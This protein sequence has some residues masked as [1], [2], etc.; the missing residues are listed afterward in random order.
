[1]INFKKLHDLLVTKI[2]EDE[3]L[4]KIVGK[5]G[6]SWT[7][8]FP[9]DKGYV[10]IFVPIQRPKIRQPYVIEIETGYDLNCAGIIQ[11]F[12]RFRKALRKPPGYFTFGGPVVGTPGVEPR[13]NVVMP[14][15][16]KNFIPLFKNVGIS[17]FV[18]ECQGE[19]KCPTCE[20]ITL[21]EAP[22]KPRLCSTCNKKERSFTLVGLNKF[23]LTEAYRVP[24]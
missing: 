12:R 23:K 9:V 1:M 4:I 16:F 11:K 24:I 3:F 22:W 6:V 18:W 15:N 13:L 7:P 10:D 20:E 17:V 2:T 8:E 14:K 5:G 21:A 19:W